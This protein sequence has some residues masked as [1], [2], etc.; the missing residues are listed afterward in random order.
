MKNQWRQSILRVTEHSFGST[1]MFMVVTLAAVLGSVF[2]AV[3][4]RQIE[5][6][7]VIYVLLLLK[8]AIVV[9]DVCV[10]ILELVKSV[11][12]KMRSALQ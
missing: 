2:V 7:F 3:A 8:Y 4:S 12:K 5:S 10:V 6:K 1:V 9:A 11:I